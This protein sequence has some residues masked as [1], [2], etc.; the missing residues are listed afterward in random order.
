MGHKIDAKGLHATESKLQAIKQAPA[1][2][3]VLELRSFL[4]LVN[5]YGRFV[6]NLST[7]LHPLHQ[8]LR[9]EIPRKWSSECQRAFQAAKDK[10][11]SSEVLI[12]YNPAL[13]LRLAGDASAYEIGTV[14]SHVLPDSTE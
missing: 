10:L 12:H 4:G 14:L 3:N 6:P 13:P 7:L 1:P 11:A 8:L 5:Y 2:R 9:Q